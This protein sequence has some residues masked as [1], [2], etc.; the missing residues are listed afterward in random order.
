MKFAKL[1]I[2]ALVAV[3]FSSSAVALDLSGVT[4][5]P[6]VKT[7]LFYETVDVVVDDKDVD[8]DL[9]E[10]DSASGQAMVTAGITGSLDS[11]WGYGLEYNIVD[12]L[13][14][15]YNLVSNT[16]MGAGIGKTILDTQDWASQAY[17]TYSPC[18][19]IL[20]NTT[21]KVGRQFLD[22]PLAFT[23]KWNLAPNSFDAVVVLN[24][25]IKNVT[26]VGAYIGKGNGEYQ[27]VT[28]GDRFEAYGTTVPPHTKAKGAYAVGALTNLVDGLPINLWYYGLPSTAT[29]LWAD[30]GYTLKLAEDTSVGLAAQYGQ[31]MPSSS[32]LDDTSG[33][34]IKAS[35]KV[36][37]F[38]VMAAY[39]S[40]DDDGTITLGNTATMSHVVNKSGTTGGY[41]TKLYTQ[42]IYSNA[43][44]VA[45]PGSDAYKVGASA[46][47][48]G[49]A[50]LT[51]QYTVNENDTTD[52]NGNPRNIL[53]VSEINVI[54][55]TEIAGIGAKL[56]YSNIDYDQTSKKDKQAI[57]VILS[58]DF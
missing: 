7:K 2:A 5:K 10:K 12:T 44:Y 33:F 37:M 55:G 54:A 29:A 48:A 51:V 8:K 24:Q 45:A 3:G 30:G 40:M 20:S 13:G 46:D 14:L 23:E 49:I 39:S 25:D 52:S 19:T 38:D 27:R 34:G 17:V 31:I 43:A 41:K 15:E 58:K 16:R 9:F 47:V 53:D 26:L 4:A 18:D 28:N 50:K 22:T 57:R 1:S 36:G 35:G 42:P 56:I 11:C 21:F 32:A 6:Y